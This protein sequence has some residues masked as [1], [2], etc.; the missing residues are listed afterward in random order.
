[1][2]G[3]I[4]G[5]AA[6]KPGLFAGGVIGGL[7]GAI[8]STVVAR[9]MQWIHPEAARATAVGTAVGFLAAAAVATQ[10]LSS[11]VGPILSTSLI[12][13][14]ALIGAARSRA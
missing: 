11:P 4:V 7:A 9:R 2:L 12:G 8:V 1:M 14:G 6:G 13:A 5:G 10:T 3:S